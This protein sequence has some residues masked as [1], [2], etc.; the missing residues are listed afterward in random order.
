MGGEGVYPPGGGGAAQETGTQRAARPL[1]Q[2]ACVSGSGQGSPLGGAGGGGGGQPRA[3]LPARVGGCVQA[4]LRATQ[5]P[6]RGALPD[7]LTPPPQTHHIIRVRRTL[8]SRSLRRRA[9]PG[10]DWVSVRV[11]E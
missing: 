9:A 11:S 5:H 7:A 4:C 2:D 8:I 6:M 3:S 10:R 1:A